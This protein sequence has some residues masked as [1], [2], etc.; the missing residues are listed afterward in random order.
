MLA[1]DDEDPDRSAAGLMQGL[2]LAA[3]ALV[4]AA[5]SATLVIGLGSLFLDTRPAATPS[6]PDVTLT[7]AGG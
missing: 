4:C 2:G 7:L 3:V 5:M 1:D 6:V